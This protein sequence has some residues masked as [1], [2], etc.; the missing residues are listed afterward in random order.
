VLGKIDREAAG[1]RAS[2]TRRP[3]SPTG[4]WGLTWGGG[5]ASIGKQV[6][7]QV[8]QP[9]RRGVVT[10][11]G[12]VRFSDAENPEY[13]LGPRGGVGNFGCVTSFTFRLH[14]RHTDNVWRGDPLP[15]R[16]CASAAARFA[17]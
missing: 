10:A 14:E 13:V 1:V 7:A 15:V 3:P 4:C 2:H 6:R 12:S 16:G 11:D 9:K 8:R 17:G 5:V